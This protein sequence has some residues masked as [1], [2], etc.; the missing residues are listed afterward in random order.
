M[1]AHVSSGMGDLELVF[2]P[3]KLQFLGSNKPAAGFTSTSH[4]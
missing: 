2:V 4:S 1:L 3:S